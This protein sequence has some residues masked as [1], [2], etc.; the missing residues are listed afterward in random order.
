MV[1]TLVTVQ[2]AASRL[3]V[4]QQ[5]VRQAIHRGSLPAV[6]L[7]GGS[8]LWV[9][10]SSLLLYSPKPYQEKRRDADFAALL[11]S[12]GARERSENAG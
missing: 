1:E 9:R 12:G 8:K 4:S 7:P 2:E 11:Q 6:R 5:A 10:P 3:Q